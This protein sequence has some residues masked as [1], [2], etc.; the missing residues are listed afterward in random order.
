MTPRVRWHRRWLAG[1]AGLTVLTGA[2]S[3]VLQPP[4]P[5]PVAA[6]PAECPRREITPPGE[7][8]F[9]D[10]SE[11]SG[12][13]AGNFAPEPP[14]NIVIN[15]HSRLAFADLDGD[16]WDDIVAHDLYPNPNAGLPY[17]HVVLR[18][19]GDGT[20]E[21]VAEASGLRDVQ[22]GFFLFG[23][24]DNDGDQDVFAG[25]DYPIPQATNRHR[26]LLNDGEGHFEELANAGVNIPFRDQNGNIIHATG[27]AVFLD[28]N[29][30][31]NLDLYLGNGHTIAGLPDQL[32]LGRG[33]GTFT[34]GASRLANGPQRASNGSTTC[35]IDGDGDTDIVVSVY[36]VSVE[37][38]HNVL[39]ENDGAGNFSNTAR[40][41]GWEALETGNYFLSTTGRGRDPE[42]VAQAS[43]V[44]GNGFGH[45]CTDI[46]N[47]GR[48]DIYQTNISHPVDSDYSRKWSDPSVLLLNRGPD[49][50]PPLQNVWLDSGLPFNEG[51]VD[52]GAVDFDNDGYIDLS[53]SR[54]RKYEPN[55]TDPQQKSWFGLMHQQPDGQFESV[56]LIS[57]INDSTTDP[58]ELNRMKAAQNHVWSDVDHDGDLDLLVGGRTGGKTGR[59]NFLFQNEIGSQNDWLALRLHG[60]GDTINR[61]A[62]GARA[63]L[64]F[65]DRTL[66]REVTSSRGM[67][68]SMDT[69]A[70]HFGLGDLGCDFTLRVRW[71]DGVEETFAGAEVG[72]NRYLSLTYGTGTLVADPSAPGEPTPT[73]EATAPPVAP[74]AT[75]APPT[76]VPPTDE[77]PAPEDHSIHLPRVIRQ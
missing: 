18:N 69:R 67:Y 37:R 4:T 52:G 21:D 65:A 19:K 3:V 49:A 38:G 42:G 15:D 31:A 33:D 27:N 34:D 17:T 5:A 28:V 11:A 13:R 29:G 26:I 22:A 24:V 58:P 74:T 35:D 64:E 70:L 72:R 56:G 9:S 8:F 50:S 47:D 2:T 62:I 53:M 32:F 68:N 43:W 36:G 23:D 77:P 39:W 16:G 25:L 6:Q 44:G 76:E 7:G 71:P 60:D 66:T 14:A 12:I 45:V 57:G 63:T 51:D 54:D 61:D 41:W 40:A 20:Y 1:L 55:Y 73:G 75:P 46:N 10:V 30:D 48:M 59:P